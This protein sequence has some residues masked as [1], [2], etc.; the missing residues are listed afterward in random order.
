MAPT[1]WRGLLDR[2]FDTATIDAVRRARAPRAHYRA[3]V[4]RRRMQI[5]ADGQRPPS[6]EDMWDRRLFTQLHL[7]EHHY[8]PE[9]YLDAIRD[10]RGESTAFFVRLAVAVTLDLEWFA[11]R[12]FL[13]EIG[14]VENLLCSGAF[15]QAFARHHGTIT[16]QAEQLDCTTTWRRMTFQTLADDLADTVGTIGTPTT[17]ESPGYLG[18]HT[19]GMLCAGRSRKQHIFGTRDC[20]S[21]WFGGGPHSRTW[22]GFDP[23]LGHVWVMCVAD[24][25]IQ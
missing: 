13:H 25:P 5:A 21:D 4:K 17:T 9:A 12:N 3:C 18:W 16:R 20:W 23:P 24:R 19:S 2:D 7:T 14:F 22:V 6:F 15:Q 8:A 1:L 10:R 11:T